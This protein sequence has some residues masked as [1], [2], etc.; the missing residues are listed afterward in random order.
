MILCLGP[1]GKD[2]WEVLRNLLIY[3]LVK[4]CGR[5]LRTK[6][7]F[8]GKYLGRCFSSH[9]LVMV[10]KLK[11]NIIW[12]TR[13]SQ[14]CT[15]SQTRVEGIDWSATWNVLTRWLLTAKNNIHLG[16]YKS[17]R[18]ILHT[19]ASHPWACGARPAATVRRPQ[20]DCNLD[21]HLIIPFICHRH[22]RHVCVKK[23]CLV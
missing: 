23:N 2:W 1:P 8:R 6:T 17:P 7:T 21:G 14:C 10:F 16:Q 5:V 9:P 11:P 19:R 22:H 18:A 3:W 4:S 20:D 15:W 12:I 13:L